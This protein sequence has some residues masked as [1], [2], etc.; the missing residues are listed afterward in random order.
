MTHWGLMVVAARSRAEA[1]GLAYL[2]AFEKWPNTNGGPIVAAVKIQSDK[3]WDYAWWLIE[4][5]EVFGL[6]SVY[7]RV[8]CTLS[9][10]I[11]S[12]PSLSAF[13]KK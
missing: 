5:A 1:T 9:L 3:E 8:C 4:T 11:L 6:Q 10:A 13:L 7:S 2:Q 12:D